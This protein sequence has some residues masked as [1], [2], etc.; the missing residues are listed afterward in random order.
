MHQ[1]CWLWG[2]L[3]RSFAIIIVGARRWMCV[4]FG[5]MNFQQAAM[6]VSVHFHGLKKLSGLVPINISPITGQ[7]R[8][9]AVIT[10]GARGDSYYEYLLKQWIQTGKNIDLWV[11]L[12]FTWR[13]VWWISWNVNFL[14]KKTCISSLRDDY[15]DA[16]E[17]IR[18][19]LVQ[20]THP[21][22]L[23]FVGELENQGK[24][25]KPKMVCFEW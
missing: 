8:S 20:R 21:S 19:K 10:L 12:L 17:G 1:N 5:L 4:W 16:V 3:G 6:N 11:V 22:N 13:L 15:L 14:W 18:S 23:T 2:E 9:S 25:F 7:L 24:S